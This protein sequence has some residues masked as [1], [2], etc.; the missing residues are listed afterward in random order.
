MDDEIDRLGHRELYGGRMW[1]VDIY[2]GY[3]GG[4][5]VLSPLVGEYDSGSLEIRTNRKK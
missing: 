1:L 2:F 3:R 5:V 4:Y